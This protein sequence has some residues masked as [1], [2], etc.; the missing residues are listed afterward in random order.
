MEINGQYIPTLGGIEKFLRGIK[1]AKVCQD[2]ALRDVPLAVES[3]PDMIY[4][5][6][7]SGKCILVKNYELVLQYLHRVYGHIPV[8]RLR[9]IL[10][11]YRVDKVIQYPGG[12]WKQIYPEN[13]CDMC[14]RSELNSMASRNSVGY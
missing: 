6:E 10:E 1:S 13:I 8:V 14:L 11:Y 4:R 3:Y 7:F 5:V 12:D 2:S 9:N